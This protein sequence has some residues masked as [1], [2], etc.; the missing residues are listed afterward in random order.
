MTVFVAIL[1]PLPPYDG[2]MTFSAN[3]L[4]PYDVFNQTSPSHTVP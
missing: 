4:H 1:D 2:I 3:S